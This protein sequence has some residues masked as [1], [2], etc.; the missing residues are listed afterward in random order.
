MTQQK[1]DPG[2]TWADNDKQVEGRQIRVDSIDG[3]FA[4]CTVTQDAAPNP[5]THVERPAGHTNV[6]Q[7]TRIRLDRFRPTS[8]GY[9]LIPA[10]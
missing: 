8:T 9:R 4:N 2:Q 6:G 5:K 3:H 7:K 10:A 1:V